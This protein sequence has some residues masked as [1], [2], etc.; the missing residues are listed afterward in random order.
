MHDELDAY[1]DDHRLGVRVRALM[2]TFACLS[3][4]ILQVAAPAIRAIIGPGEDDQLLRF[5]QLEQDEL[6]AA[7]LATAATMHLQLQAVHKQV[8]DAAIAKSRHLE[9]AAQNPGKFSVFKMAS[10]TIDDFH[11]GLLD[12]IGTCP[13]HPCVWELTVL[14]RPLF[15]T[16]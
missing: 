1:L 3:H 12:R 9:V 2:D 5:A 11:K 10:G 16:L 13:S 15:R 4:R 7:A 6:H 8:R 14:L